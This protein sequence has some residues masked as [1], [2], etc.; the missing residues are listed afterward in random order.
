MRP[1]FTI[2]VFAIITDS[3]NRVLVCQR[4]D[5]D[6]WNLPGGGME[7]GES[8]WEAIKREV[9]EEIGVEV[10][11]HRL[12][13]IY[14][15]PDKN[16]IVFVFTCSIS[17]GTPSLSDEVKEI[18]YF[19]LEE[20]PKNTVPKQVERIKDYLNQVES[21]ITAVVFKVQT[22]KSSIEMVKDGEL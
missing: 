19:T 17:N 5:Y 22:G 8:P 20:L 16:E 15:K 6:L 18:N 11:V 14:S 21:G 9:K 3:E 2:G 12:V 1:S 7:Q 13:G 4:H 10:A